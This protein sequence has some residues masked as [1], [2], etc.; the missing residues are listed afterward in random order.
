[1]RPLRLPFELA[2]SL[3]L[4]AAGIVG[5]GPPAP[6]AAGPPSSSSSATAEPAPPAAPSAGAAPARNECDAFMDVVARTTT[7]RAEIHREPSTAVRSEEWAT[8]TAALAGQAKA[9]PLTQED[10]V[11]EA[12]N[13]ATRMGQLAADLRALSAAEKA[14]HPAKMVAAHKRVL[15]TSEQVEVITREPAARCAGDD[16][17]KLKA[18]AGR[19]PAGEIQRVIRERFPLA[20][21]CYEDGL[22]R[23][24]KL[25]GRVIVRLVIGL[26][27]KVQSA[28]AT[29]PDAAATADVL[30]PGETGA[31]MLKD[32]AVTACVVDALR[33][34]VFP[35]PDGGF[36]TIVYPINFTSGD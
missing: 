16:M 32:A 35:S 15:A 34:S 12:A 13:L 21:R 31:P 29:T 25:A 20:Q 4:L 11:I 19:L 24:P 6:P 18:T 5:C 17:K 3:T 22:K 8:R 30:T 36:I 23:D 2:A 14:G 1:M 28:D 33:G 9:L 27:G 7:L 26:D 10:L